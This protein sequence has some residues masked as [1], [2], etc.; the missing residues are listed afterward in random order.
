MSWHQSNLI[1]YQPYGSYHN[2]AEFASSH[3]EKGQ[4]GLESR[5]PCQTKIRKCDHCRQPVY[6]TLGPSIFQQLSHINDEFE[7]T[8]ALCSIEFDF[9]YLSL[10]GGLIVLH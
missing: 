3:T 9:I 8:S 6:T 2:F 5:V 10:R 7:V 4:T 1:A